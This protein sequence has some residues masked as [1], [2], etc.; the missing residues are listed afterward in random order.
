MKLK[1]L[2]I[3]CFLMIPFS[4][5]ADDLSATVDY[6]FDGDTF[7]SQVLLE[8]K[9]KIS[10]R[11]RIR[12]IDAPE[13][14]GMCEYETERAGQAWQRLRALLPKGTKVK[15]SEIKDDK[16]LGR[17]DALV[18]LDGKDIG[19]ILIDE[20]LVRKYNGGKRMPWCPTI[21]TKEEKNDK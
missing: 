7:S 11:V 16:Y 12:N 5:M 6:V 21:E 1:T 18:S 10:V 17:I 20:K 15:L 9:A 2:I 14:H 3:F 13:I 8:N 19:K 4:V